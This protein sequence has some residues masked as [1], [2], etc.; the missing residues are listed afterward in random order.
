LDHELIARARRGDAAAQ[1][2]LV[3]AVAPGLVR[4]ARHLGCSNEDSE[5]LVSDT[6]YRGIV[7]LRTL[8]D[9]AKLGAWLRQILVRLWRDRLRRRRQLLRLDELPHAPAAGAAGPDAGVIEAELRERAGAAIA[10]LPSGQRAVIAL[11]LERGSIG[12]IA[13]VLGSTPDRVKAN[14]WHARQRLA[15]DLRGY[16]EDSE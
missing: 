8:R 5:E 2:A 9:D 15:R 16:L 11:W 1:D 12:E 7:R 4:L 14:L 3:R 10:A 13:E 6:L